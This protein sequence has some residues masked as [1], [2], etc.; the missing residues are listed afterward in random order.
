MFTFLKSTPK[1]LLWG[2][3]MFSYG[4]YRGWKSE[5]EHPFDL[6]SYKIMN[7]IAN[8]VW[9]ASPWGVFKLIHLMDRIEIF[10]Y[11]RNTYERYKSCYEE[12]LG[13]NHNVF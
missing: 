11:K 9:Y 6:T 3:P 2:V 10:L 5:Y 8:G 12:F 7:S 13:T 1:Y 4:T